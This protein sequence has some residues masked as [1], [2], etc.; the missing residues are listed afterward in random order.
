M[1]R[2]VRYEN[3]RNVES[4]HRFAHERTLLSSRGNVEK[5]M[6][7]RLMNIPKSRVSFFLSLSYIFRLHWFTLREPCTRGDNNC[8]MLPIVID[9]Y[10]MWRNWKTARITP[11]LGFTY[12]RRRQCEI[13]INVPLARITTHYYV[14]HV[15]AQPCIQSFRDSIQR[16]KKSQ[17]GVARRN[18]TEG[19]TGR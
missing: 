4:S 17:G 6:S 14:L 16:R 12:R 8:Q 1:T 19:K 13:E 7:T 10:E 11:R 3:R 5:K 18:R 2:G 9:N 15:T